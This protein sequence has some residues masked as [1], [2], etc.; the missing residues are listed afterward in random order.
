MVPA[1]QKSVDPAPIPQRDE[2]KL[3]TA[4]ILDEPDRRIDRQPLVM[5]STKLAA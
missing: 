2:F 1:L 5:L 3:A 4:I